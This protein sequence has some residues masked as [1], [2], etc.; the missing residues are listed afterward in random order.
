MYPGD[1]IL[2]L[3]TIDEI[4]LKCDVFDSSVVNRI[5]EPILF[6]FT[7]D[8]PSWYKVFFQRQTIPYEKMNKFV[9][10]TITFYLEDDN[11]KEVNFKGQTLT[12]TL[13]MTKI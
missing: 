3:S 5:R 12:F 6:S 1:K 11:N 13:Q 8:K 7:L 10:N 9:L 2:N 4:D